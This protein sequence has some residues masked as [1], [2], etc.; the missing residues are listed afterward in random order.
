MKVKKK[1]LESVKFDTWY[2]KKSFTHSTKRK[3]RGKSS[4]PQYN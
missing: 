3:T 2:E 1:K 4:Y